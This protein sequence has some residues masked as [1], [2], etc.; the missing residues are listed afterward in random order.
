MNRAATSSTPALNIRRLLKAPRTRVF[1]AWTKA[2]AVRQWMGPLDVTVTE[3]QLDVREGGSFRIVMR[4]P[5]GDNFIARG[6]FSEV[7][8][9]ERLVYT[10][11]WEE[12]DP[13]LEHETSITVEFLERGEQT[14][15]VFRQEAFAS[16]ES[17]DRH[18][19]GWTNCFD[20]LE[21]MLA[22]A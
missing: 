2:E 6:V 3:A 12:D 8:A 13:A 7:R 1:E 14:E 11:R 21:R 10:W 17:R 20:K 22:T 15:L 9:P 4:Q 5:G 16:T 19:Y 18:E